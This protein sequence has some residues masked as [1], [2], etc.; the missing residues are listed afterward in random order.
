MTLENVLEWFK[1]RL[2]E[3]LKDAENTLGVRGVQK[4]RNG[5]GHG[6]G[7]KTLSSIILKAN[8][9]HPRCFSG[10]NKTNF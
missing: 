9:Y 10:P 6:H 7:T 5:D 3:R 4:N 8:I 1:K 2:I